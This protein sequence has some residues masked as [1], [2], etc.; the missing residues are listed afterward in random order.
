M[1]LHNTAPTSFTPSAHLTWNKINISF[2]IISVYF[3]RSYPLKW[4]ECCLRHL[5][6]L[7][8]LHCTRAYVLRQLRLACVLR[9]SIFIRQSSC[10]QSRL[11]NSASDSYVKHSD[12]AA[13]PASRIASRKITI[14]HAHIY[15]DNNNIPTH[16]YHATTLQLRAFAR[17]SAS[18]PAG[19]MTVWRFDFSFF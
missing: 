10:S 8:S 3:S 18:W 11:T 17:H 12:V 6:D 13:W 1:T 2:S 15:F 9:A 5:S 19:P 16:F 4:N 7:I 14:S